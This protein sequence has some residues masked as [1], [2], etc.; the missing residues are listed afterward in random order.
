MTENSFTWQQTFD[1]IQKLSDE[2]NLNLK[3]NDQM[4]VNF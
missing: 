1:C 2:L 4:F 3:K